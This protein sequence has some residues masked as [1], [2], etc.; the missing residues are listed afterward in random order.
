[1]SPATTRPRRARARPL[2]KEPGSVTFEH[3]LPAE[4]HWFVGRERELE[5][6]AQ[7][8]E[9][10]PVLF[11][12]GI[13]GIGKTEL[14]YRSARALRELPAFRKARTL[15][16]RLRGTT[17]AAD[18][19]AGL[20]RELR[21]RPRRGSPKRG[22]SALRCATDA[23]ETPH[24]I[25]I[26]ALEHLDDEA[27]ALLLDGLS[28]HQRASRVL[29]TSRRAPR[30]HVGAA[31]I[32]ILN[33]DALDDAS[34]MQLVETTGRGLCLDRPVLEA[35]VRNASGSPYEIQR[36]LEGVAMPTT[37]LPDIL[38]DFIRALPPGPRGLLL[39]LSLLPADVTPR[40]CSKKLGAICSDAHLR[41]LSD[42]V[43]VTGSAPMRVHEIV[44]D[45]ARRGATPSEIRAAA[46][47]IAACLSATDGGEASPSNLVAAARTL[48][49]A[50]QD[51]ACLALVERH[52]PTIARA[53]LDEGLL[54]PL[55]QLSP[56]VRDRSTADALRARILFRLGRIA[57]AERVLAEHGGPS[58]DPHR[59]LLTGAILQRRGRLD[60]ALEWCRPGERCG[61][62]RATEIG[63]RLQVAATLALA[64]RAAAAHG[65]LAKLGAVE[66]ERDA[67]KV[68]LVRAFAF[69]MEQRFAEA[70]RSLKAMRRSSEDVDDIDASALT[71]RVLVASESDDV[72]TAKE[73]LSE[74]V[75]VAR[76]VAC[77]T[78]WL[79]VA[80]G[81]VELAAGD[82][83]SA[84]N[85]LGR[86]LAQLSTWGDAPM[87]SLCA[88]F[89][90]R[91]HLATGRTDKAIDVLSETSSSIT[92]GSLS[93]SSLALLARTLASCGGSKQV[94][95]LLALATQRASASPRA[96]AV[97]Q[98]ARAFVLGLAGDVE[99]ARTELVRAEANAAGDLSSEM[100]VAL[101]R[102]E[103]ELL[104]GDATRALEDARATREYYA[105]TGRSYLE[106]R[107]AVSVATAL[108]VLGRPKDHAVY[109][110]AL[111]RARLLIAQGGY[112]HLAARIATLKVASSRRDGAE[113]PAFNGPA[114]AGFEIDVF[115]FMTSPG[116]FPRVP[117]GV[118]RLVEGLG[119]TP[120]A[121]C[122]S[123]TRKARERCRAR[124]SR[125]SSRSTIFSSISRRES[126]AP[127]TSSLP[128]P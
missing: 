56:K 15:I 11:I 37:R 126:F 13:P 117:P 119:G 57:D 78:A 25:I 31:P 127:V 10:A 22:G 42:S 16:A 48:A 105:S 111:Q 69:A 99:G 64:G 71:L 30:A 39:R 94:E 120:G 23:L 100:S 83:R 20:C 92:V 95:E 75:A 32:P 112:E 43:L 98:Q 51:D 24:V 70:E 21:P 76:S 7:W 84:T 102:A 90:A 113:P 3:D 67:R 17:A 115:R 38:A 60:E 62:D 91:A 81:V 12:C 114:E 47:M 104:G 36:R 2:A 63:R 77:P 26:D 29:V 49:D 33:L 54:G 6:A 106:A 103:V 122:W 9:T 28:R 45:A 44:R 110:E 19:L 123:S 96:S 41:V 85:T 125:R 79:D 73:Y 61:R 46:Q 74:L 118:K 121:S 65:E 82:C 35:L 107:A 68:A 34:A 8:L 124:A 50:G 1:M 66:R 27:V 80:T 89:L 108:L 87:R 86:A 4:V 59:S 5:R 52:Y 18:L 101:E 53:G 97:V 93:V 116:T 72:R 40:M 14:A 109:E 58:T 88:Q 128:S 55:E